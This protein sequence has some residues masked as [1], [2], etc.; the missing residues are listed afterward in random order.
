M[1]QLNG[2]SSD[3]IDAGLRGS[4]PLFESSSIRRAFEH[5]DRDLIN[6]SGLLD[7]HSALKTLRNISGSAD[8]MHYIN[9]L[10]ESTL[11]LIVFMY[12]RVLDS[13]MMAAH[14]TIH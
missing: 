2:I 7:A 1:A 9:A 10:P 6:E 12:F 3:L 14:P 5:L 11:D 13:H 4:H 8:R